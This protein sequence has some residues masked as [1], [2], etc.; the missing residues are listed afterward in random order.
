[1][2]SYVYFI[3]AQGDGPI[4]I[5]FT[6]AHPR[7]RMAFI[8]TGCPW[9]V[10][11]IG[12]VEGTVEDEQ[13]FHRSLSEFRTSGEW[14]APHPTVLASI[15][16]ALRDGRTVEAF[17]RKDWQP[18][19]DHPLCIW[20]A[21]NKIRAYVFAKS[22]GLSPNSVTRMFTDGV[23]ISR[24]VGRRIYEATNGEVTPNDFL[25]WPPPDKRGVAA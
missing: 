2:T 7:K 25:Y 19:Y 14:F 9:P 17:E 4:K 1:M 6:R 23:W 20:L 8:Q 5:G 21:R 15:E 18:K 16:E 24:D 13:K 3:R 10:S 12:A 11:L 22:I